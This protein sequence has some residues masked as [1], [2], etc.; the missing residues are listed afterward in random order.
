[1]AK[2]KQEKEMIRLVLAAAFIHAQLSSGRL[3]VSPRGLVKDTLA[4]ADEL[5]DQAMPS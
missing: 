1:M 4:I 3:A 5:L 2:D